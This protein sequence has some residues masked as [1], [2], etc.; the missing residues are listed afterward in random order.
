M[1][2]FTIVDLD[3]VCYKMVGLD[4]LTKLE[5]TEQN[6]AY[7]QEGSVL[8]HIRLVLRNI[9][10]KYYPDDKKEINIFEEGAILYVIGMLHDI[11]KPETTFRHPV[12]KKIVSYNHESIS[13]LKSVKCLNDFFVILR[14]DYNIEFLPEEEHRFKS[15]VLYVINNH[16]FHVKCFS[17]KDLNIGHI[18]TLLK[19]YNKSKNEFIQKCFQLCVEFAYF[20]MLGRETSDISYKNYQIEQYLKF[21]DMVHSC[22]II[23]DNVVSDVQHIIMI[24]VPGSGKSVYSRSVYFDIDRLSF[25][26]ILD[27]YYPEDWDYSKKWAVSRNDI[28]LDNYFESTKY[29]LQQKE[30]SVVF[31]LCNLT[32]KSR[33]KIIRGFNI[34]QKIADVVLTDI[35]T[36]KYR[37]YNRRAVGKT[38]P[39]KVL[40]RK[41]RM[42]TIPFIDEDFDQ[43]NII[44]T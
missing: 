14:N 7:H 42:L 30:E 18:K 35:D 4:E 16:M 17:N 27:E 43:I 13:T 12:K 9:R 29:V 34:K 23:S 6:L 11:G 41:M 20:D 15:M 36:L 22:D 2:N 3:H 8:N 25:D 21:M 32:K 37:C 38:I 10:V 31:D 19:F 1:S 5:E 28:D 26:D 40:E 24:G 39:D 44:L 33:N